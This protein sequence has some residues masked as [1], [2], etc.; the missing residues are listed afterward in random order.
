VKKLSILGMAIAL[1]TCVVLTHAQCVSGSDEMKVMCIKGEGMGEECCKKVEMECCGLMSH[2]GA[3]HHSTGG[4]EG[5]FFLCCAKELDLSAD[6]VE[7]LKTLQ[8][9]QKKSS[10]RMGAD[11]EILELE[12][13]HLLHDS[14]PSRS[15]IDGKITAMG[16]LK[17]KMKRNRV[18]ALLDARSVLT[19]EQLE[20]SMNGSCRCCG[21][22]LKKVM[23]H[24][25]CSE[26][27]PCS[28]KGKK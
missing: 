11:L 2:H 25:T 7:R 13:K 19:K 15:A 1:F 3:G 17:T 24:R 14:E 10:I 6:Q 9:E 12:F 18:H 4:C 8:L 26:E 23:E 21:M 22:G 27:G 16:D 20:K 5:R 28:T